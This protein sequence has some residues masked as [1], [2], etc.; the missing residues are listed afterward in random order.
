MLDS[1]EQDDCRDSLGFSWCYKLEFRQVRDPLIEI[2]IKVSRVF[3]EKEKKL[4]VTMIKT[5]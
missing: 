3:T 2:S 1:E 4:S 5:E